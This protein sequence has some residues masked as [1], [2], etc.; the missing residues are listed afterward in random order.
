ML[1]AFLCAASCLRAFVSAFTS[2]P[3]PPTLDAGPDGHAGRPGAENFVR[4][5]PGNQLVELAWRQS[6]VVVGQEDPE[7]GRGDRQ[8]FVDIVWVVG[9]A[10]TQTPPGHRCGGL[11]RSSDPPSLHLQCCGDRRT[12]R[13]ILHE[14]IAQEEAEVLAALLPP[15]RNRYGILYPPLGG[16]DSGVRSTTTMPSRSLLLGGRE[17]PVAQITEAAIG[18]QSIEDRSRRRA[19]HHVTR[20]RCSWHGRCPVG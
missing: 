15:D 20:C 14:L 2:L 13:G 9:A 1:H 8:L 19:A 16:S 6:H 12:G 18:Q 3:R 7:T 17:E 5:T 10:S 4:G 11:L